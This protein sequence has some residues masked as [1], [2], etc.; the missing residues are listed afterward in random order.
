MQRARPAHVVTY[1]APVLVQETEYYRGAPFKGDT[2]PAGTPVLEDKDIAMR[3]MN[4]YLGGCL[5]FNIP[6]DDVEFGGQ[7]QWGWDW[8]WRTLKYKTEIDDVLYVD[9]MQVLVDR[10]E[11]MLLNLPRQSLKDIA[12]ICRRPRAVYRPDDKGLKDFRTMHG[13][14][15][16]EKELRKMSK[17][18]G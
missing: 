10:A 5:V 8:G 18:R 12:E 7:T 13:R 2:A 16:T 9:D 4:E 14:S 1:Y 3:M 15:P 6:R 17:R 11:R